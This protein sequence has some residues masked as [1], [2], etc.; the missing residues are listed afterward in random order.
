MLNR[1]QSCLLVPL[2]FGLA[3]LL[4]AC[5][6]ISPQR[7]FGE[8]ADQVNERTGQTIAW[9]TNGPQDAAA[10]RKLKSLLA[11]KL[12]PKSAVQVALLNNK[13]LQATY[14]DL[15]IAQAA[16]VQAGLLKN[17]VFDGAVTWFN[18]AGN[19]PN[20]AFG[21][22]WSFIDLFYIPLR[23]AVAQSELEEAKLRVALAVLEKSAET[24]EAFVSY[25]A[26]RQE[27]ELLEQVRRSAQASVTA[28]ASL[29]KAGN[30]TALQFDQQQNQLTNAKL[31]LAQA[32]AAAAEAREQ[33]NVLMGLL[34]RDTRWRAPRRLPHAPGSAPNTRNVESRAVARSLNISLGRQR[35]TTLGRQYNLVKRTALVPDLEAGAEYEREVEVEAPEAEPGEPASAPVKTLRHA[36]GPT[37]EFEVPIFDRGQAKKAGALMQILKAENELWS[38]AVKVR[39]AARL[40]RARVV[41]AHKT[42]HYYRRRVLPESTRILAGT[43]RDYNAMQEDVFRLLTAKRQQIAVARQYIQSLRAYWLAVARFERLMAGSLPEGGA[44]MMPV[45]AAAAG[46]EAAGH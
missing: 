36:I 11:R 45:A 26:A 2:L 5:A 8:V 16:L 30:L 33:L 10:H 29:R 17:P 19:T 24:K 28:A 3:A 22:A 27:I 31:E 4:S 42:A 35:L 12:T 14:A 21:V 23:K 32:K 46:G 18:D 15:G 9:D 1:S 40:Q 25:V 13:E 20:L 39:S 34:G 44:A 43:Q 6:T 7:V 37:F 38:L 41:T